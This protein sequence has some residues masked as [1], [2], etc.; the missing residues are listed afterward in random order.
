MSI[1][2]FFWIGVKFF[3]ALIA[4]SLKTIPVKTLLYRAYHFSSSYDRL[5]EELNYMLKVFFKNNGYLYILLKHI[6][7]NS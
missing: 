1:T 2:Y 5:F 7:A 3:L 4:N 6:H